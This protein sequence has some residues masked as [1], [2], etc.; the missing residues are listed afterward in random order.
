MI[1]AFARAVYSRQPVLLLDD[2]LSSLDSDTAATVASRLFWYG[3]LLRKLQSTV[4]LATYSGMANG[5]NRST[6]VLS[7][8][9]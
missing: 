8:V 4:F 1:E 2:V 6:N 5:P 9:N 3:C 7:Y